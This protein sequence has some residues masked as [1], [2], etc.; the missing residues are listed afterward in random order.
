[1]QFTDTSDL[2]DNMEVICQELW[3]FVMDFLIR[4][5][6]FPDSSIEI[7]RIG[8]KALSAQFTMITAS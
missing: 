3:Y 6:K 7:G 5:E 1:M 8:I 2:C 4:K